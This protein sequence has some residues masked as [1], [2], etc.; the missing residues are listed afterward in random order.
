M[1]TLFVSLISK[2]K[3]K[4]YLPNHSHPFRLFILFFEFNMKGRVLI[5]DLWVENICFNQLNDYN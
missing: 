4:Y 3:I 1:E 5:S 2:E